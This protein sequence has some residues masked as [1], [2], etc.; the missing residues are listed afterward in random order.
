MTFVELPLRHPGL[1]LNF[2]QDLKLKTNSNLMV[3][4]AYHMPTS[5]KKLEFGMIKLTRK[6][7]SA[8]SMTLTI[9][10]GT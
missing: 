7:K 8:F 9:I 2:L 5:H 10:Y 3:L 4:S 1:L 6:K